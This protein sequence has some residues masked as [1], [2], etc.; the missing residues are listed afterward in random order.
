MFG[1]FFKTNR[2]IFYLVYCNLI[3]AWTTITIVN[4]F[5]FKFLICGCLFWVLTELSSTLTRSHCAIGIFLIWYSI[6]VIYNFNCQSILRIGETSFNFRKRI[7]LRHTVWINPY[8]VEVLAACFR[9]AWWHALF[10]C[11]SRCSQNITKFYS[12]SFDNSV[13]IFLITR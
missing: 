13:S 3:K 7:F 6:R 1:T 2:Y 8:K 12:C 5:L 4:I 10:K 11:W 9:I